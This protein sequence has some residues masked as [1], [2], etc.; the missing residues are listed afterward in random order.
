MLGHCRWLPASATFMRSRARRRWRTESLPFRSSAATLRRNIP[1][2][3]RAR[4]WTLAQPSR[5]RSAMFCRWRCHVDRRWRSRSL[6]GSAWR[7][8]AFKRR[9][10]TGCWPS[11]AGWRRRE[12]SR[13][14]RWRCCGARQNSRLFASWNRRSA[15]R[16]AARSGRTRAYSRRHAATWPRGRAC[17]RRNALWI[18]LFN[19]LFQFG[20]VR[21]TLPAVFDLWLRNFGLHFGRRTGR[22][23]FG[24]LR[25]CS[26]EELVALHL[27]KR[28][29]FNCCG[30]ISGGLPLDGEPLNRPARVSVNHV[31]IRAVIINHIILHRDVGHVHGVGDVGNVLRRR[32]DAV[33]QNRLTDKTN[34]T[35]VVIFRPDI[36]L[37]IHGC[38]DWLSFINDTRTAWRQGRPADVIA[39]GPPRNP[40]RSP[41]QIASREPEPSVV[42]QVR[43]ATI[44]IGRPTEIFV[45][46]P[47][48]A[49]VG[50]SPV[51]VCVRAPIRI[52]HRDVWLPAVAVAFNLDPVATGEIIVKEIDRYVG[53]TRLRKRRH[54][55]CQHG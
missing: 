16:T 8:S 26:H 17:W 55:Q 5:W 30:Q 39:T 9:P 40:G 20:S 1:G 35:E 47:R 46:D 43:P 32:K 11:A 29:R 54:H 28:P 37:D 25:R 6:S 41:I 31:V 12:A 51:A 21:N 45:T 2:N 36:E 4:T 22:R 27:G 10:S 3:T 14:R 15:R 18:F 19:L 33:P 38:A 50:V 24:D 52:A 49:V 53:T 44:V 23:R 34:I 48:P 7:R 42:R 13:R